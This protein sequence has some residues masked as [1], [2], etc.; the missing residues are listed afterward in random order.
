MNDEDDA[1]ETERAE[2]EA[3]A[4]AL[5]GDAG[6]QAPEDA[7]QAALF[8][9]HGGARG[10]LA[11][12]RAEEILQDLLR[13]A[14]MA[15]ESSAPR[16]AEPRKRSRVLRL[17]AVGA[18]LAAAAALLFFSTRSAERPAAPA[19]DVAAELPAASTSLLAA[20][21]DLLRQSAAPGAQDPTAAQRFDR[22]LRAYRA[23]MFRALQAAYP[24][25]VGTLEPQRRSR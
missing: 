1:S 21:A 4:R 7:L 2:A 22:E 16:A 8:L 6:V 18:M 14:P 11:P 3:L 19:P 5:D 20:Q 25:P 12:D 17:S 13:D 24:A 9:R 15:A 23:Q 10:E